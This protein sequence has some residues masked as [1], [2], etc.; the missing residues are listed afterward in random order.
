MSRLLRR[1][2]ALN[3]MGSAAAALALPACTTQSMNTATDD[4]SL[5][6][7][8]KSP[9]I[10][11]GAPN[12]ALLAQCPDRLRPQNAE[13]LR[14]HV[15][16]WG[17]TGPRVFLVH[18]GVQGG[19]GGGPANFLGQKALAARGWQLKLIDR[20]GFGESPSRGPDDMAADAI[21]VADQIRGGSHLIG[22]SF[23]G[24]IAMLAAAYR[25]T[26]V[27]TL[28]LIEPALQ[29]LL[30][31]A[32]GPDSPMAKAT[33]SVVM[34]F[35]MEAQ[36]PADFA[37]TFAASMGR[38]QGGAANASAAN[39]ASEPA[40]ATALGCSLLQAR[41]A[42]PENMRLAANAVRAAGIPTFVISGGYSRGQELTAQVV[43][44]IIGGKHVVVQS[45][46]HF[47]QRDA[48]EEFNSA[49]DAFMRAA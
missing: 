11:L 45:P 48:P 34:K 19:I 7:W 46:S 20:P 12:P 17:D 49:V 26:S 31:T 1:R 41:G 2:E 28:I 15:T 38:D 9:T 5:P 33:S 8:L 23:G 44:Q 42:S 14:V 22:H 18:G 16:A 32:G 29:P 27:K 36:T 40:K 39:I 25:P 24:A 21:L 6:A 4:A 35:L 47:V 13:Q 3:T 10:P 37:L 30:L 43:A